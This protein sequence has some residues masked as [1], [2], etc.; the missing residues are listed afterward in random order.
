MKSK[1]FIDICSGWLAQSVRLSV[2]PT[3][4]LSVGSVDEIDVVTKIVSIK[5]SRK[6]ASP[7]TTYPTLRVSQ[8]ESTK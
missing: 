1:N 6:F 7:Q 4:H 2:R 5:H 8:C 3:I